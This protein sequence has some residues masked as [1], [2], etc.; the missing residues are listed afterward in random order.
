MCRKDYY[1]FTITKE[2]KKLKD[3]KNTEMNRNSTLKEISS[4]LIRLLPV[5]ENLKDQL[6]SKI[7]LALKT[8]FEE[9][10]V[11]TREELDQDRLNLER[12]MVRIVELEKQLDSLESELRAKN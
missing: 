7:D 12:A 8:A 2:T 9:L 3:S 6:R 4:R 5:A 1:T 11:L 10:G